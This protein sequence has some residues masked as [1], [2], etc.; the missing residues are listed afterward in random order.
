[1]WE[2]FREGMLESPIP[3]GEN[4]EDIR[5]RR[6]NMINLFKSTIRYG[7]TYVLTETAKQVIDT[8]KI[9]KLN[10]RAFK[11][12]IVH[13]SFYVAIDKYSFFKYIRIKG[14][15]DNGKEF[16]QIF[17]A[18]IFIQPDKGIDTYFDI[19]TID[20]REDFVDSYTTALKRGQ[21]RDLTT[22]DINEDMA[23]AIEKEGVQI[24]TYLYF[25]GLDFKHVLKGR[26]VKDGKKK[27][28][29]DTQTDVYLVDSC[30]NTI[31][32]HD[33]EFPVRGH[34]RLQPYESRESPKYKLIWIDD[35]VKHG[36]VR[37]AGRVIT[38][39]KI[40]KLHK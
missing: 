15:L 40:K 32:I 26:K 17:A 2:S 16:D 14:V 30:W 6:N 34:L 31:V 7:Y 25:S 36:Y 11:D 23:D 39:E 12:L 22:D 38:E 3:K 5:Y 28:K 19:F 8:I 37:R 20:I 27:F 10:F 35:F 1:M 18:K 13:P 29:N 21:K 33:E 9:D 24:L 4:K